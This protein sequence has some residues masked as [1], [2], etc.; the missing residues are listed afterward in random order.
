MPNQW[1][2]PEEVAWYEKP[3]ETFVIAFR[4]YKD[5]HADEPHT[6]WFRVDQAE[7]DD[8]FDIRSWVGY[9]SSHSP[10]Q[11]VETAMEQGHIIGVPEDIVVA[12]GF[13]GLLP[14]YVADD[15]KPRPPQGDM[16]SR[17]RVLIGE[18]N[19]LPE[20]LG[21]LVEHAQECEADHLASE[22]AEAQVRYLLADVGMGEDLFNQIE[23]MLKEHRLEKTRLNNETQHRK[24]S[25][26][27]R[28]P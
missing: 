2:P 8:D 21:F 1:H 19:A 15:Y 28:S 27:R 26:F 3:D 25:P 17:L 12:T 22:G 20:Y 7:L 10:E 23:G 14:E 9:D 6:N 24:P 16:L 13:C 18:D 4:S 5:G 11:N